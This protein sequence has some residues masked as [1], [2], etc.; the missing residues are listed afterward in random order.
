MDLC[1][2]AY[3]LS[4]LRKHGI[5]VLDST[6]VVSLNFICLL[7]EGAILPNIQWLVSFLT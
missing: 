6:G 5:L 7:E 2:K 4:N 1:V 3:G